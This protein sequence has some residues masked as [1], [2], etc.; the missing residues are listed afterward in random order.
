M[1]RKP[2]SQKDEMNHKIFYIQKKKEIT[3]RGLSKP[4][5]AVS[6]QLV[7]FVAERDKMKRLKAEKL[8][9][10]NQLR[11]AWERDKETVKVLGEKAELIKNEIIFVKSILKEY[12]I[13]LFKR[14]TDTRYDFF[15]GK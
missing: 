2:F 14:G 3:T 4:G 7:K 10:R 8:L 1:R 6:S 13:N 15:F 11:A 5:N 12:Y 9:H